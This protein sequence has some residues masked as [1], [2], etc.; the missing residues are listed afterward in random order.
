MSVPAR[1]PENSELERLLSRLRSA[2][3]SLEDAASSAENAV[4]ELRDAYNEPEGVHFDEDLE[5]LAQL[6]LAMH[7]E[8]H[9]G[10]RRWCVHAVCKRAY[11][12]AEVPR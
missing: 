2:V 12:L 5:E 8:H 1:K 11:E 7:D 4:D 6:V 3:Y 9:E 10:P